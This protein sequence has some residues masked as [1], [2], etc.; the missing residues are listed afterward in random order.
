MIKKKPHHTFFMTTYSGF[1]K[2]L[3]GI[4]L[5]ASRSPNAHLLGADSVRG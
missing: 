5:V 2:W 1:W 3:P 4:A